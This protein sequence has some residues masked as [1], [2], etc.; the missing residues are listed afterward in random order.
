MTERERYTLI[1]LENL[2][3]A[4]G[5]ESPK[6]ARCSRAVLFDRNTERFHIH[7]LFGCREF[8]TEREREREIERGRGGG[9]GRIILSA[10][11]ERRGR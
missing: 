7:G 8:L 6:A 9:G 4:L 2:P 1:L 5:H 3:P 10:G 11:D